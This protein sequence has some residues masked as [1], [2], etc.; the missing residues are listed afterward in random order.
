MK[1]TLK[2]LFLLFLFESSAQ[3]QGNIWYFGNHAGVDFSSGSPIAINGGETFDSLAY[4]EGTSTLSD[5]FGNLL[6]YTNG[7]TLWNKNHQVMLNGDSLFGNFS[8]TQ[9]SIIIPKPKSKKL[10][11]VFTVDDVWE[12]DSSYGFRYSIVDMC[13]ENED[14]IVLPNQK[15]I[16]LLDGAYEK[17][18]AV[19]HSNGID[20]W[21]VSHKLNT[22][23]YYA[24]LLNQFGI[25]DTVI[26]TVGPVSTYGQGQLKFSPNGNL[27]AVAHN[28]HYGFST[29]FVL[30]DFD[31]LSGTFSN[32]I[33]LS[34]NGYNV[35]GIEFSPNSSVLYAVF[36]RASP[37][38]EL[39]IM[40]F[41][42]SS[43]NQATINNSILSIYQ[44]NSITLRGLQ[45][46]PDNKI[47]MVGIPNDS[48]LLSINNPNLIGSGCN[49]QDNAVSLGSNTGD[50]TLP[51]FVAGFSYGNIDFSDCKLKIEELSSINSEKVLVKM[52]D[53][54]GRETEDK[55]NTLLIYVFSDG[56]TEKVFKVE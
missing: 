54:M 40:Q 17:V 46:A 39:R 47:Y 51:T 28:Q 31:N 37:S 15:N 1:Y 35:Y 5:E 9:S 22:N 42:I 12:S 30:F 18:G 29:E 24:Y 48:Y 50:K 4:S 13:N 45:I 10:Y 26:S 25:S 8:S 6:M 3:N 27:M 49:V 19:R 20:Y 2:I 7:E 44:T 56:T 53:L 41:D 14:G 43:G 23:E 36:S 33:I 55:I 16:L 38:L 52:L 11:Y 32:P 21:V 34:T